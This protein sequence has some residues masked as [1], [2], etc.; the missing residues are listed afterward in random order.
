MEYYPDRAERVADGWLIHDRLEYGGVPAGLGKTASGGTYIVDERPPSVLVFDTIAEEYRLQLEPRA[1]QDVHRKAPVFDDGPFKGRGYSL[2]TLEDF[3]VLEGGR[4]LALGALDVNEDRHKSV[5]LY[6]VGGA[7]VKSWIL[8]L[9][10]AKAVFDPYNPR[11]ILVLGTK[12]E[13]PA[14]LIEVD[15]ESYPSS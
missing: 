1:W 15:G 14:R 13:E 5:E 3:V 4:L 7:L 8:P 11:R 10:E 12:G 6:D 2:H 9:A